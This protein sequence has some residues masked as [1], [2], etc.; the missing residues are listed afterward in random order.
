LIHFLGLPTDETQELKMDFFQRNHA[1]TIQDYESNERTFF[2]N[3]DGYI[4]GSWGSILH[5]QLKPQ[6]KNPADA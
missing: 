6:Q 1:L 5:H 2:S 4:F 3:A